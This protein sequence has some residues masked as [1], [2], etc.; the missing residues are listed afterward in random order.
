VAA[1]MNRTGDIVWR[2]VGALYVVFLLTPL[3]LVVL[4]SFTNRGI[5]AFPIDYPSLQWWQAMVDDPEFVPALKN[6]LTIGST[7]GVISAIIGTMAAMGLSRIDVRRAQSLTALLCLPLMLPPLLLAVSLRT[8]YTQ[9]AGIPLT[10]GTVIL[11]HLLF[12]LPFVVLVV[13]SRMRNFD[14]RVVESARDLGASPLRA[15]FTVT[16][17]IIRPTV[18]GAALIAVS[19]SVDD[20]II[21][22]FTIGGGVTLPTFV[23]GM[24]RTSL[25]PAANAVGTLILVMT[26]GT[27]LIALRLTRYR[28]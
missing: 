11:S 21:T 15:F 7:V 24:I 18:V 9:L 23:F 5:A 17:P 22:N 6:S 27:T 2:F 8:F 4:F 20:F 12:T 1:A 14:Y 25:T 3:F 28:G 13:Y 26:V 10:L 16:L 19:L